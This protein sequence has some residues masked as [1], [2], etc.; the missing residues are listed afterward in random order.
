MFLD[1]ETCPDHVTLPPPHP[2]F[3]IQIIQHL[4]YFIFIT[5]GFGE[6]CIL[7]GVGAFL[8]KCHDFNWAMKSYE[9]N[10]NLVCSRLTVSLHLHVSYLFL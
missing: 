10:F 5:D 4:L 3:L 6:I 2:S 1:I 9:K 8:I 7:E